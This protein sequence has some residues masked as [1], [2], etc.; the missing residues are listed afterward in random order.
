MTALVLAQLGILLLLL[1]TAWAVGWSVLA[2]RQPDLLAHPIVP[3]LGLAVL[4]SWWWLL[5][6]CGSLT[7]PWVL[8]T[9][10]AVHVVAARGWHVL[11]VATREAARRSPRHASAV[12]AIVVL[13]VL[14]T[15]LLALYPPNAFDETTYHLAFA[16]VLARDGTLPWLPELRVPTF[17]VLGEALQA[18]LLWLGGDRA[19]HLVGVLATALTAALLAAWARTVAGRAAG[20]LAAAAWLGSPLVTYIGATGYAEPP[21]TLFTTAA[22]FAAWRARRELCP[23]VS[24]AAGPATIEV[25]TPAPASAASRAPAA[26]PQPAVSM[27]WLAVAGFLAGSAA[28]VKYL[29]LYTVAVLVMLAV[30]APARRITGAATVAVAALLAVA[31][32]H[33]RLWFLT[34]N[35]VVPFFWRHFGPTL[36]AASTD[37]QSIGEGVRFV[38]RLPYDAVF[39]RAAAGLQP[40]LSL[41]FLLSL[42]PL[43]WLAWRAPVARLGVGIVVGYAPVLVVTPHD[44][45]YLLVVLPLWCLLLAVALARAWV[46]DGG[47]AWRTLA[48]TLFAL[49][50]FTPGALYAPYQMRRLGPLPVTAADT[51]AFFARNLH[52]WSALAAVAQRSGADT[53]VYG[54]ATEN[55]SAVA[56]VRLLGAWGGLHRFQWFL[57]LLAEPAKAAGALRAM[58]ARYLLLPV[59]QA[60]AL[61]ARPGGERFVPVLRDDGEVVLAV[62]SALAARP[63]RALAAPAKPAA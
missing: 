35:P 5:A 6:L 52:G 44:V 56:P 1:A 57:P 27:R 45:R 37:A 47:A 43:A 16:R 21:L 7:P 28:A 26:A 11:M 53:V 23:P 14:P 41:I 39:H 33:L 12:A 38:L 3:T 60:A 25:G 4:G 54:T 24:D 51:T 49:V 18:P 30:V 48:L 34:G 22:L 17:P 40:P 31:P 20:W 2:R 13:A 58:G 55:L 15:F 61:A 63:A 9:L 59:D 50:V 29:G 36:W 42:P 8:A 10:V 32:T 19:A 62:P 46:R